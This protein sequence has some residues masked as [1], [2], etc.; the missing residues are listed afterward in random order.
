MNRFKEQ[1][2]HRTIS[3]EARSSILQVSDL[4]K[5]E[6][7]HDLK[8]SLDG[9]SFYTDPKTEKNRGILSVYGK[10]TEDNILSIKLALVRSDRTL[11]IDTGKLFE[12]LS[13]LG[14][15]VNLCPP[16]NE[17]VD[18][19]TLWVEVKIR[20]TPMSISREDRFLNEMKKLTELAHLLQEETL[21]FLKDQTALEKKYKEIRE[22]IQPVFPLQADLILPNKDVL[23]WA[24][25]V[26]GYISGGISV[27]I[28]SGCMVTLDYVMSL[29]SF[30]AA[31]QGDTYG[32]YAQ[33][34][35]DIKKIV[36]LTKAAP[37][38]VIVPAVCISMNTGVYDVANE[39][40]VMLNS[41]GCFSKACGFCRKARGTSSRVFRR[42]GRGDRSSFTCCRTCAGNC[43][44]RPGQVFHHA[45]WLADRGIPI[46]AGKILVDRVLATLSHLDPR[47]QKRLL[48]TTAR[49]IVS[50]WAKGIKVDYTLSR[51]FIVRVGQK[52]ESYG[53]LT[54][55]PRANRSFQ[56]QERLNRIAD[57]KTLNDYFKSRLLAQDQAIDELC[58]RLVS[59]IL[60]RP[61]HQPIR[62]CAEGTPA[63]GKSEFCVLLAKRLAI[64][65][66]NIDAA[67]MPDY[68]MAVTQL[69]GSGRGF[70]GSQQSGR[71]EQIAKHHLGAV[72]EVSDL[73]H[74][75]AD[76]RA[77]LPD[78]FLQSLETGEAQAAN[79]AMFSCANLIFAFTMNLP[80]G[81]DESVQKGVG[82]QNAPDRKS[83]QKDVLK[84][85]KQLLSGAFLSRIGSP[86]L[87]Q[88]LNG[89]ALA[90][91]LEKAMRNAIRSAA[92][93]LGVKVKE[94]KVENN[95]GN[96]VR[97]SIDVNIISF[98]ARALLE[99]G[100]SLAANAFLELRRMHA[101]LDGKTLV[102]MLNEEKH[103][104][105]NI[106]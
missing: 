53:G 100:R 46:S 48:P 15:G 59:E 96:K 27:G 38:I 70:V 16:I 2:G 101:D 62:F 54:V 45:H 88:A 92:E 77:G 35:L 22:K 9:N 97:N 11:R 103:V 73:D 69:L 34:T 8:F 95:L 80:A 94:V 42:P 90:I 85:M 82:F 106:E 50:D 10:L 33:A 36:E 68:H 20:A 13:N 98:G 17:G 60:T 63:T 56:L 40:R 99:Q 4:L 93:R 49:K 67:G 81:M 21:S 71:L 29:L 104:M 30:V 89:D 31:K 44:R 18:K 24:E 76:V 5:K 102:I 37:G 23:A 75:A 32:K 1:T 26:H 79:G 3:Y 78:L 25:D 58:S 84:E 43:C 12:L 47:E 66:V 64:P 14:E 57:D 72:V 41:L 91:I 65:Y 7:L 51:K 87:F 52:S 28:E 61:L 105:V 39:T 19:K 83:I 55:K 86:I 74:A 6:F